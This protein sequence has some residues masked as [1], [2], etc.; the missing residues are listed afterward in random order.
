MRGH[1]KW[2]PKLRKIQ[3]EEVTRKQVIEI[4][5]EK[6]KTMKTRKR[7]SKIAALVLA[8]VLVLGMVLPVCAD[9]VVD[10]DELGSIT[11]H[12]Y[13]L[14]GTYPMI[15][16]DGREVPDNYDNSDSNVTTPDGL[17]DTVPSD[18]VPLGE[19]PGVTIDDDDHDGVADS[20]AT[21]DPVVFHIQKVV[22]LESTDTAADVVFEYKGIQYKLDP[23]A[24]AINSLNGGK[25][26]E[27]TTDATTGQATTG[28]DS[29]PVGIY[30]VTE[31]KPPKVARPADPFL[32]SIPT[33][34]KGSSKPIGYPYVPGYDSTLDNQ[35]DDPLTLY[36][37]E[38]SGLWTADDPATPNFNELT[39]QFGYIAN[40]TFV[41]GDNPATTMVDEGQDDYLLYDVHVY[42]KNEDIGITKKVGT[43]VDTDDSEAGLQENLT[44]HRG[45]DYDEPVN[46]Y[47]DAD[48]PP[49]IAD[50]GSNYTVV[51]TFGVGLEYIRGSV[52]VWV[53]NGPDDDLTPNVV[54]GEFTRYYTDNSDYTP[55]YPSYSDAKT[56]LEA[57]VD[58]WVY[59]SEPVVGGGGKVSIVLTDVG[60]AKLGYNGPDVSSSYIGD[61]DQDP[62]LDAT[63]ATDSNGNI[64]EDF[65][66]YTKLHIKISTRVLDTAA[67]NKPLENGSKLV[68]VNDTSYEGWPADYPD[69][70]PG[71]DKPDTPP[72]N[73]DN[74]EE[75]EPNPPD[76][77]EYP[78][79][80]EYP[81]DDYPDGPPPTTRESE[82]PYVY[83]GGL[84]IVKKDVNDNSILL[85]GAKFKLVPVDMTSTYFNT[86]ANWSGGTVGSGTLKYDFDQY[87]AD[88]ATSVTINQVVLDDSGI[89]SGFV[90][91]YDSI[92]GDYYDYEVETKTV[93]GQTGYAEFVGLSYGKQDATSPGQTEKAD[94]ATVYYYLVETAAPEGY[95]LP[96]ANT[97][98]V[99][100]VNYTSLGEWVDPTTYQINQTAAASNIF[101]VFNT[102]AFLLPFTGGK[103]SVVFV[104]V[105]IVVIGLGLCLIVGSKKRKIAR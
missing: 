71:D 77:P 30:L 21:Y 76:D 26:L 90:Q 10:P 75:D 100:A 41:P 89:S 103:G 60:R 34:I 33:T 17:P 79:T 36:F 38:A 27:L 95:N 65:N 9:T 88:V 5:D 81:T 94:A 84:H 42:P 102:K 104:V 56:V 46:W 2:I 32:V 80:P 16:N 43:G 74:P 67:L 25:G 13:L 50:N 37:N 66:Y 8:L 98:P 1:P 24:S 91:R 19:Q 93:N 20:G 47:I 99:V 68:F 83:T 31:Q 64:I 92:S 44:D 3:G 54:E 18:A 63:P 29:L 22:P 101:N 105:G 58:Y 28:P 39:G 57:G 40:N 62:T 12:K 87:T 49:Q 86:A 69:Q 52:E 11:I 23:T 51:D 4:K 55:L 96:D 82:E 14:N 61:D 59:P 48:L 53:L 15:R 78:D 45:A 85:D 6:E 7:M 35:A 73:P 70:P 72:E 97:M